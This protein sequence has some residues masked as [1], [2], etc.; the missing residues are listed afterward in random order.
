MASKYDGL[1][2]I[3]IQNVGG[4]SNIAN[5]THCVTRLRFTLKDVSKANTDIL[6]ETDGIV[7]VLNSGGQYQVVI[8]NHVPDVYKTVVEVGHLE[9]LA[10]AESAD[11]D[12]GEKVKTN[13]F[14]AFIGIITGCFTP[15]LG[16]L[17]A[18]GIIKGVLALLVA[19]GVLASDGTD[20]TYNILYSLGDSAFYFLPP[21]IGYTAAKKFK[22][23][24]IEGLLLGCA[25][26][27]PYLST[28][29]GYAID[30]LFGIPVVMPSSGNYTSSIIPIICGVAFAAWIRKYIAK[31]IP[32]VIKTFFV[33]LIT[34]FIAFVMT[35]Y[36]IG[37]VSALLAD[38]IGAAFNAIAGFNNIVYGL[39]V[40]FFWQILVMFGLH[41]ALVPVA[42]VAIN[43]GQPDTI[44]AAMFAT[45]FAQT[46]ACI[47]IWIKTKDKKIKGLAPTAIIS[48]VCGVTEP[49]IYGLT[50]PKK[51]PFF[52]TC[53]IAGVGG[54]VLI[55]SGVR[56]YTM[57]GMGI[58]GYTAFIT[59]D[60]STKGMVIAA[61]VSV[62]AVV[63][64][65]ISE[66]LFYKDSA[67]KAAKKVE[68]VASSKGEI[69]VSP[70]KGEVK[71][72]ATAPD[73]AFASGALGKGV[74]VVPTEGKLY[75]PADGE[76]T[77]FFPTGHAIGMK[78]D[79]GAEIL[80][81]VGM[82]TV[83]LDGKCFTTK[84]KQGD[85]VK[86]G[87]LL[88]EFDIAG[89]KE[90]GYKIDT[91]VIISNSDDYADVI[92]TDA[93]NASVGDELITLL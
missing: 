71:D 14:N 61:I 36:V 8:G 30:K 88:L 39:F 40:G 72:L 16:V 83:K 28:T 93:K 11:S 79:N 33:P 5:I 63:A 68:T 47:G 62:C 81:H 27:Y 38:W 80:I 6:K 50:L 42:M 26:I 44:L 23:P 45:T 9:S 76:I 34:L 66:L 17:C 57:A 1:A 86:K 77:V 7:T 54:A 24:E 46:G 53:A 20:A 41:W 87:D 48:G 58:F 35:I 2:R 43:S 22:M 73:E 60:N 90:A 55:A 31:I 13:P 12:S 29:S 21:I 82:D 19:V 69:V 67:P 84:A 15:F 3:I 32:D 18:M 75:A 37:P 74:V 25:I 65:V 78:T 89:I 59:H 51:S 70:L 91:P 92:P 64:G 10:T 56:A 85:K 4:K 49:A 52:R